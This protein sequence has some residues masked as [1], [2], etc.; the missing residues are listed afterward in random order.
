M[1]SDQCEAC[2]Q[3]VKEWSDAMYANPEPDMLSLAEGHHILLARK[4][5]EIEDLYRILQQFLRLKRRG[6]I[7]EYGKEDFAKIHLISSKPPSRG[8]RGRE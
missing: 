5:K 8:G 1:V 3:H 4:E 2:E 7:V 6:W